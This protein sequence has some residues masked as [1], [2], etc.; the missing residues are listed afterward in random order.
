MTTPTYKELAVESQA[1]VFVK[2]GL[3]EAQWK[4]VHLQRRLLHAALRPH[5]VPLT[6]VQGHVGLDRQEHRAVAHVEGERHHGRS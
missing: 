1:D 3:Q 4:L 2:W 5:V 6:V